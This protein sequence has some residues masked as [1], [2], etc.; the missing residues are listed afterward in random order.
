MTIVSVPAGN[1]APVK[2][3]A[4]SPAPTCPPNPAPAGTSATMRSSRRDRRDILG[5]DGIAIHRRNRKRRLRPA[6]GDILGENAAEPVGNRNLLGRQRFERRKQARQRFFDRNHGSASQ[7]SRLAARFAQQAQIGDDHS[8]V[9]GLA[10]VVDGQ[11]GDAG[12]GQRL[13]LDAGAAAQSAGRGD[14]DRGALGHASSSTSTEVRASGWHSGISSGGALCRHDAGEPGD[15]EHIALGDVAGADPCRGS[16][17]ASR[18]ARR[19]PRPG[20]SPPCRRRRP[21]GRGPRHRDA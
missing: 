8:A 6:R 4:A 21:C 11:R 14:L 12:G 13:H 17:A 20:R 19:R 15:R 7:V 1:G 9:D 5:A 2:M 3:R 10:H 18:R 16:P